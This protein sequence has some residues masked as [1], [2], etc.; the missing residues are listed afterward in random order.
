MTHEKTATSGNSIAGK[1]MVLEGI[2]LLVPII[3]G[4]QKKNC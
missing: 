4:E 2:I 3:T 1:M